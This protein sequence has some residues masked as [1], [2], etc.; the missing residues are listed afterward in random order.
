MP[1]QERDAH[2]LR[3]AVVRIHAL[4]TWLVKTKI[5]GAGRLRDR[6]FMARCCSI[7]ADVLGAVA[8]TTM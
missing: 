5:S 6:S 2:L 8:V 7:A 3:V 4:S 1:A